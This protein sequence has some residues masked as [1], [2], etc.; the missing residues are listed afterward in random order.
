[1]GTRPPRGRA[2]NFGPERG[3]PGRSW[4]FLVTSTA[5]KRDFQSKIDLVPKRNFDSIDCDLIRCQ[6]CGRT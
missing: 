1:M 6:S 3:C 2:R 5:Q 4:S